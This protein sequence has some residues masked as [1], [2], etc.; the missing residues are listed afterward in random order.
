MFFELSGVADGISELD[1]A[2]LPLH[3]AVFC[4][5]FMALEELMEDEV[6]D[7]GAQFSLPP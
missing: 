1:V 3:C 2:L 6:D 7:F 4:D 5:E